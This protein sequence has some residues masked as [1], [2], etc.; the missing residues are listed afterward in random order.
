[1]TTIRQPATALGRE[2]ARLV[3]TALDV[4]C[5]ALAPVDVLGPELVVRASTACAP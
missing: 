4:P 2:A 3:L 5:D 1:L